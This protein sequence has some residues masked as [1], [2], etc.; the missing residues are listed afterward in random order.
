MDT[1]EEGPLAALR[2][3]ATVSHECANSL[4]ME[5][6]DGINYSYFV[7][8]NEVYHVNIIDG[9]PRSVI[10]DY[11]PWHD[12]YV[13]TYLEGESGKQEF[14]M[15]LEEVNGYVHDLVTYQKV[16]S[17][18]EWRLAILTLWDRGQLVLKHVS[19]FGTWN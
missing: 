15:V 17:N 3:A 13:E 19:I 16:V 8:P 18:H 5:T 4:D 1:A 10:K 9:P 14:D 12:N 2:Q 7:R 11:I 6:W